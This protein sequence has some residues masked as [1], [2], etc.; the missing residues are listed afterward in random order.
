[1]LK[2]WALQKLKMNQSCFK[3]VIGQWEDECLMYKLL[4]C[5]MPAIRRVTR[6]GSQKVLHGVCG[7]CL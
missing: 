6:E 7:N 5:V 2:E 1:M 4:C 3:E